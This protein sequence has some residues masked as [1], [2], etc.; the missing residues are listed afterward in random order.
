MMKQPC[1]PNEV[2]AAGVTEGQV[3]A[4]VGR[5]VD[6]TSAR[7]VGRAKVAVRAPDKAQA[8]LT[9]NVADLGRLPNLLHRNR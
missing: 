3:A 9:V 5:M 6:Q 4:V 7:R 2:R 1:H 8:A